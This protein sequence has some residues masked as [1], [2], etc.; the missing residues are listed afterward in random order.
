M[1]IGMRIHHAS[2]VEEKGSE[3]WRWRKRDW[4]RMIGWG[5][6]EPEREEMSSV[7]VEIPS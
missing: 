1:T 5:P 6:N 2:P 3:S 4:S 7:P